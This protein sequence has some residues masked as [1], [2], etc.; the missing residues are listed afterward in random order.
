[1]AEEKVEPREISWRTLLPWT[2]LF[3]GFQVALDLN[4][5]I[6][7]AAGIFIMA[8]G[9][10]LLALLFTA[11]ESA[12][13]PKW[14]PPA[15]QTE[16]RAAWEKFQHARDHWNLM[17]ETAGVGKAGAL[18]GATDLIDSYDEYQSY[19][20]A[21]EDQRKAVRDRDDAAKARDAALADRE[22]ARKASTNANPADD[23]KVKEAQ[24]KL[25]Q[26]EQRLRELPDPAD[27]EGFFKKHGFSSAKADD[28]ASIE[29]GKATR[30]KPYARL[31]TWPWFE[32]RGPN[33]FLMT[34]GQ[35]GKPWEVGHFW[36]WLLTQQAPVL[37]EPLVKLL[38][39]VVYLFHP[40][41]D[42]LCRLY[43]LCVLIWTVVVWSVSGGAITRIAAVQVARG[44][45][46]GLV[47]AVRFTWKRILSYVT[48][49]LFP[50][51]FIFV[52]LVAMILFGLLVLI[53]GFGDIIVAGL[54]W[55]VMIMVGL[56]MA[57]ALVGLVGWPLMSAT[58]SA[59]GTDSW[60]AV[61]RAYSYV[62]QKPWHFIWYS[63]VAVVYGAIIVFF[64]GFMGSLTVYLAKWGVSQT[65][66][67]ALRE[68]GGP[69][70]L[71]AY[72]PTSFGWRSLLLEGAVVRGEKIVD[73]E[74]RINQSA[75][76]KWVGREA[77]DNKDEKGEMYNGPDKLQWYNLVGAFFVAVWLW[78]AFLLILGFSYIY[79]WSASTIVYMLLRRNVDA[80]E[81]DEVYLDEEE[82]EGA[83][84]GPLVSAPAPPP[85]AVKQGTTSLAMV[86]A[87]SPRAAAPPPAAPAAPEVASPVPPGPAPPDDGGAA[88]RTEVGA[89]PTEPGP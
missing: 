79:F 63:L 82:T 44:E 57:I 32:D 39:P 59:E 11:G 86:D 12:D 81:M 41:A 74:G 21:R 73:S 30:V 64:V 18:V 69:S 83:F 2:E 1:M 6:L 22:A 5:L 87:P 75:Y 37:V 52:L 46:I 9:W 43:F 58:V 50:L 28:L 62:Y 80:A 65:P 19:Q 60:E 10:W 77:P 13:P 3:R 85:T 24:T 17:Y 42:L 20:A 36:E 29:S 31:S 66:G 33:P 14:E 72:A 53:P 54:F 25:D 56:L 51:A 55:P 49:P 7:A 61:S 78:V 70:F 15:A 88:P 67:M 38:L 4:K 71:F 68:S 26:A 89:A 34:T 16:E 47:E 8:L 76:D 23:P 45:K 84:G 40:T 35:L 48:A 27:Y